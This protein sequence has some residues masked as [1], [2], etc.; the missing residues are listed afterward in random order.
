M[1]KLSLVLVLLALTPIMPAAAAQDALEEAKA[2]YAAAEY[3]EALSTLARADGTPSAS[4]VEVEQYR[5][6]CL[7]ALGRMEDAEKAVA[8]IVE[9]DPTYT[10]SPSV[11]SPRVLALVSG[12]RKKELPAVARRLLDHGRTAY[13][14]KDFA[15]ARQHLTLL[16]QILD[17]ETMKERPESEDL[18]V[19]AEG[20]ATLAGAGA[21]SS[22]NGGSS[23]FLPPASSAPAMSADTMSEP[24]AVLQ[25]AP[26]WVPPTGVAGARDY[27]GAIRVRIGVDGRVRSATIETPTHPSYDARLLQASRQWLYKPATKNGEPVESERVIPIQLRGRQ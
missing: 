27:L 13:K 12:M 5:A 26:V 3:E 15:R 10:P 6:F 21:P 2:Q 7:I 22:A 23:S 17:D 19:L 1:R 14:D 20:F 11:A 4:R 18:R 9:A 25:N 16:L 24:L 8:A